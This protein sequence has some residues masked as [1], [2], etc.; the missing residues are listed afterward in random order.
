[1]VKKANKFKKK[2]ATCSKC[3][4]SHWVTVCPELSA[5]QKAKE[6][7]KFQETKATQAKGKKK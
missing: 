2:T 1:M 7:L 5:L 3:K 6:V 4:G